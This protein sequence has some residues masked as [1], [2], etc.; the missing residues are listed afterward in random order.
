MLIIGNLENILL[1]K[2][3]GKK[4]TSNQIT[5]VTFVSILVSLLPIFFCVLFTQF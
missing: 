2:K 5:K 4:I 3:L 1:G